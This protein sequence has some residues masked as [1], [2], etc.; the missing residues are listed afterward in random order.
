M[1]SNHLNWI[2][3]PVLYPLGYFHIL[4]SERDLNPQ[5]PAW[6]AG[7]LPIE[8]SLHKVLPSG[9]EPKT[10]VPETVVLPLKLQENNLALVGIAPTIF[11]L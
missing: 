6:K 7:T 1:D 10:T 2:F 4:S 8:L 5:Q 9:L 11:G 3:S